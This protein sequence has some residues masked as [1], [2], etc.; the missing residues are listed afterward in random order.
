MRQAGVLAGAGIYALENHIER[1]EE[2]H[3]RAQN[4][5][6][7]LNEMAGVKVDIESISTNMVYID[8]SGLKEPEFVVKRLAE[9]GVMVLAV[10]PSLLRAV[11]H[12]DVDDDG[13]TQAI[14]VFKSMLI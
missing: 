2:D 8:I 4:L 14:K 6:N 10:G 3:Q 9:R 1:L 11:T 13:I 7:E 12:L 5:G